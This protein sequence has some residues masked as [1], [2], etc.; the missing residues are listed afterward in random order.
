MMTD[1]TLKQVLTHPVTVAVGLGSAIGHA[2][3]VPV[4]TA[5]VSVVWANITTLFTALSVAGFILA[6]RVE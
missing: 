5:A 6:P 4:I 1:Y 3:G 2:I